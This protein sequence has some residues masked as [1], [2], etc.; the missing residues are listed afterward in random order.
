MCLRLVVRMPGPKVMKS[1]KS[2]PSHARLS[3]FA[4]GAITALALLAGWSAKD[5]AEAV[6]KPDGAAPSPVAV[7]QTIGMA[8]ENNG[9]QWNGEVCAASGRPRATTDALDKE[10]FRLVIKHRGRTVVNTNYVKKKIKAARALSDRTIQRRLVEAGLRWLRRRKKSFVPKLHLE[11]RLKWSSWV[12]GRTVSTLKRWAYSDGTVFYLARC[13]SEVQNKVRAALGP[14][15]WRRADGKDSLWHD[16]I[17]PS[18]YW[19]S[20][21]KPVR[22]WGLLVA[23]MLFIC[24]LPEGV[25]MTGEV[26]AAVIKEKFGEWLRA[27]L[28]K[29]AKRGAVLI[30]D[31]E[32]AL[33][34][35]VAR[36]AM[37]EQ[38]IT[39]LENYPKYSQDFNAIGNAWRE[40]RARLDVTQPTE[41][42]CR[43]AFIRR[44]RNA[45]SW[46]N[47][48]RRNYFLYICHNQKERAR[49]CQQAKPP[50]SRTKH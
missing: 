41:M 1:M 25:A 2:S 22:V 9:M 12:L 26:Y 19:K 15:V 11:S 27:G 39:L 17:G 10:I 13:E 48:H 31:H 4:R 50:G 14:M 37:K 21:G 49:D 20:Q 43:E 28:G 3:P 29:M 18:A 45:V 47:T 40:L 5:I 33:W 6:P 7:Q 23:G 34:R 16:C 8:K 46:I 30:Q 42:E 32:K 36:D 38:R 24:I 44:L 35:T